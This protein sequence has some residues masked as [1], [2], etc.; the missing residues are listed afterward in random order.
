MKIKILCCNLRALNSIFTPILV[1]H[2]KIPVYSEKVSWKSNIKQKGENP[3]LPLFT[4]WIENG[5]YICSKGVL[6][7]QYFHRSIQ[8]LWCLKYLCLLHT[9]I[10]YGQK[11]QH[12]KFHTT[13]LNNCISVTVT[14]CWHMLPR[15]VVESLLETVKIHLG[16]FLLNQLQRNCF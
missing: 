15:E 10:P 12:G 2:V 7:A 16:T 8:N 14:E 9:K 5:L 13:M 11:Q 4:V 3:E 1:S 6:P